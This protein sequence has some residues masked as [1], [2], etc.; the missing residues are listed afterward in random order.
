MLLT[1]KNPDSLSKPFFLYGLE[2]LMT[3][4]VS[5]CVYIAGTDSEDDQV[6]L[7][8]FL[9]TDFSHLS[10]SVFTF[11]LLNSSSIASFPLLTYFFSEMHFHE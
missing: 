6:K 7:P 4:T 1:S 8:L 2:T 5:F 3:Y 9:R 11:N 10:K